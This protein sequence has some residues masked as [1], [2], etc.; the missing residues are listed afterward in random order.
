MVIVFECEGLFLR[1]S[2]MASM[3]GTLVFRRAEPSGP[4]R[5]N[6]VFGELRMQE[7]GRQYFQ[8]FRRELHP[9]YVSM[10]KIQS[11]FLLTHSADS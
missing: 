10:N 5:Q 3:A 9:V 11:F 7:I 4:L 6:F 1:S 2:V 8:H